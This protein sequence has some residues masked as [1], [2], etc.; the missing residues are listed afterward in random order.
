MRLVYRGTCKLELIPL[1]KTVVI[2]R[3]F[4]LISHLCNI[5]YAQWYFNIP[6]QKFHNLF[7]S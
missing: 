1:A 3:Y 5:P 2:Q 7:V 4:V 6:F